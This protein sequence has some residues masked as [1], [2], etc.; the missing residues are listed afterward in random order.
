[1]DETKEDLST[2]KNH[3][4]GIKGDIQKIISSEAEK[5]ISFDEKIK[6]YESII[7]LLD[8]ESKRKETELNIINQKITTKTKISIS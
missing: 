4:E 7:P 1:M 6:K 3:L 2:L 8:Q 5:K